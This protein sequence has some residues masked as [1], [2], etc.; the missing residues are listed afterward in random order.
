M[1]EIILN[2]ENLTI[3]AEPVDNL[4]LTDENENG[5]EKKQV[6]GIILGKNKV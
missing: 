1:Q 6:N 5:T 4:I 2:T 3:L